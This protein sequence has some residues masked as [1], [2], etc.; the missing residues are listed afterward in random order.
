[1]QL[2][3]RLGRRAA[4]RLGFGRSQA[5][6]EGGKGLVVPAGGVGRTGSGVEGL[7]LPG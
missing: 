4:G 6:P 2:R 5:K 1:M 7:L 3:D